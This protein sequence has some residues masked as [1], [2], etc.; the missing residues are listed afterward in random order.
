MRKLI[1]ASSS[2]SRQLLLKRLQVPFEILSPDID[3]TPLT[4]ETPTELVKRLALSKAEKIA[5]TNPDA[6]VIGSD[7]VGICDSKII[8]KPLTIEN[9]RLQLQ[10]MSGKRIQFFIGLCLLDSSTQSHQLIVENYD[11][12]FRPLSNELID[13]YLKK[14]QPLDCAGSCEAEGLGIT[15]IEEFSGKDFT[16]LIG[17]PLIQLT[18]MLERAGFDIFNSTKIAE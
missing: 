4:E 9:A 13:A 10:Q 2:K 8:G 17:L 6:L 7:Q 5:K 14:E 16:A 15:L 18:R 11:V 12:L 3:E 1:L